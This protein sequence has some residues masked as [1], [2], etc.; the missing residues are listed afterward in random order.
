MSTEKI[1]LL[2]ANFKLVGVLQQISILHSSTN[3]YRLVSTS[4]SSKIHGI[5]S[6]ILF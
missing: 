4:L 3:Q 6:L 5:S 2:I 1:R